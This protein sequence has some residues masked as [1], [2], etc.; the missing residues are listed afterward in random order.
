MSVQIAPYAGHEREADAIVAAWNAAMGES[1]PLDA[2]LWRQNTD[3]DP[4]HDPGGLFVAREGETCVGFVR[5]RVARVPLGLQPS[6]PGRGWISAIAVAPT[7]QR[8][9]VGRQLLQRA[10][11]WLRKQGAREVRLGGD[12]GHFFPGVPSTQS[13]GRAF[14][15]STGYTAV[16]DVCFDLAADIEGF[17]VPALVDRIMSRNLHFRVSECS[18]RTVPALLE[19]LRQTFPG[20]WLYETQLRLEAERSPQDI[21]VLTIGSRVVGFAHTFHNRSRRLGPSV[22]WRGL[23]G[24]AFGGLGPMG[25]AADVRNSG[26]GYVLLCESVERLRKMGV[27]RMAI[28]WTVLT[29]FYG[30]AGFK[31]WKEYQAFERVLD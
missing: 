10:E 24:P 21:Q 14:F 12:P 1:F 25:V 31:P 7:H 13:A 28:D 19:F 16:G 20:R 22:Y 8:R 9:G 4:H 3:D 27:G 11:M 26:L 29:R 18:T 15:E 5:A 2:R 6:P 30:A 17:R 23:L